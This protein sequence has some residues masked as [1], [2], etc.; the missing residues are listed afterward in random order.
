MHPKQYILSQVYAG[1][2]D[3]WQG[4]EFKILSGVDEIR[5]GMI[6]IKK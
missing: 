2:F 4:K 1:V 5:N 6:N 3:T